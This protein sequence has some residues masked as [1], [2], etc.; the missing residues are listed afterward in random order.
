[1]SWSL[2]YASDIWISHCSIC[3]FVQMQSIIDFPFRTK[4]CVISYICSYCIY[5]CSKLLFWLFARML[6][7]KSPIIINTESFCIDS[8]VA[9]AIVWRIIDI[10]VNGATYMLNTRIDLS[11]YRFLAISSTFSWV[12]VFC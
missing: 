12:I 9:N 10:G 6:M 3:K 4:L 11:S 2:Q 7:L 5:C 1:M 8:I